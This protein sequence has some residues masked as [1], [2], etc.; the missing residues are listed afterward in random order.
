V[1]GPTVPNNRLPQQENPVARW[2]AKRRL[3][4]AERDRLRWP[5]IVVFA[6]LLF[7]VVYWNYYPDGWILAI[8]LVLTFAGLLVVVW[9]RS[10]GETPKTAS[11]IER[12]DLARDALGIAV[13]DLKLSEEETAARLRALR[14]STV[15][16]CLAYAAGALAGVIPL[17]EYATSRGGAGSPSLPV[18]LAILYILVTAAATL[19]FSYAALSKLY[20]LQLLDHTVKVNVGY[21]G[22]YQPQEKGPLVTRLD[23]RTWKVL[24]DEWGAPMALDLGTVLI[25]VFVVTLAV[26]AFPWAGFA[27][28]YHYLRGT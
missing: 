1:A 21:W 19:L 9:I 27:S 15:T 8:G 13:E 16:R 17:T 11:S 5:L 2:I 20:L 12:G 18:G 3:W 10:P 6:L 26:H 7:S 23:Y 4:E 22:L 25:T 14:D 24:S 28:Q